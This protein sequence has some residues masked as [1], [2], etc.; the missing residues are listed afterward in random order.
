MPVIVQIKETN[1][2]EHNLKLPVEVWQRGATWTFK[3]PTTSEIQD[4]I[5]D[6]EKVLPDLN[7]TNNQWKKGF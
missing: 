7:R 4:I 1:G 5:L 6:P 2:K 3:V